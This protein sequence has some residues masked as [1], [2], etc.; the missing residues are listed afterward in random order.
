MRLA[1]PR[2]LSQA[3]RPQPNNAWARAYTLDPS[4]WHPRGG[5]KP[6]SGSRRSPQP[7]GRSFDTVRASI[8]LR[9]NAG[10]PRTLA[11]SIRENVRAHCQSSCPES[12][13][14]HDKEAP[15]P[16]D[17]S[18]PDAGPIHPYTPW[19]SVRNNPEPHNQFS[20]GRKAAPAPLLQCAS[21]FPAAPEWESAYPDSSEPNRNTERGQ[22]PGGLA[23][24]APQIQ[25]SPPG[26]RDS[27]DA[28][29]GSR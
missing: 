1:R 14:Q 16:T 26:D 3:G 28:P 22:S 7:G 15:V 19:G 12:R 5:E 13:R 11:I 24:A 18:T 2:S 29:P 27:D 25:S 9:E 6:D 20:C 21:S 23:S 4:H 8:V 10:R 17:R